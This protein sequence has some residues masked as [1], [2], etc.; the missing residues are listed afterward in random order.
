M[1]QIHSTLGSTSITDQQTDKWTNK[2]RSTIRFHI[3]HFSFSSLLGC[4]P[5]ESQSCWWDDLGVKFQINL[6]SLTTCGVA[7]PEIRAYKQHCHF[8]VGR[9]TKQIPLSVRSFI[10]GRPSSA[11]LRYLVKKTV[12]VLTHYKSYKMLTQDIY[13]LYPHW[14]TQ[15]VRPERKLK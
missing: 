8:I 14:C 2:G 6:Q 1:K 15:D 7:L 11:N 10:K 9:P 3:T 5:L 13:L 12:L 4:W